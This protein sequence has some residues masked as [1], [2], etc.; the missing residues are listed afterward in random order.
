MSLREL[1]GRVALVT[2]ASSGIG[3]AIAVRLGADRMKV[4]LLA[5]TESALEEIAASV[6]GAGGEALALPCD[7]RDADAVAQAVESAATGLGGLDTLI[8]NAAVGAFWQLDSM[9]V[10]RF[11]DVVATNL[12]GAFAC[13]VAALPYLRASGSAR[14]VNI[15][16]RAAQEGYPYLS[17]YSASKHGL[18]GLSESVD[19]EL[20]DENIRC[21]TVIVGSVSTPFHVATIRDGDPQLLPAIVAG[22]RA[23]ASAPHPDP[24]GMLDAD[25]VA[26]LVAFLLRLP[27]SMHV[28]PVV[29]RPSHDSGP[30]DLGR[31][32][33]RGKAAQASE[34]G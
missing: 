14:I 5:R 2:G 27:D 18:V 12:R 28:Q 9:D 17:A 15:A 21:H 3:R 20:E 8:N 33:R 11:D 25:D 24:V 16:S 10:A 29:I 7:L 32:I 26:E 31:F 19:A 30:A 23:G 6:Q 4:A 22:A 34:G 1:S 13:I